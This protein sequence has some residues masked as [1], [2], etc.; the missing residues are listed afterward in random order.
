MRH[1]A[2]WAVAVNHP[3]LVSAG[4]CELMIDPG[5]YIHCLSWLN[6]GS[7]RPETH[8]AFPLQD[9]VDLFLL[10]I[11]PRNLAPVRFQCYATHGEVC[12]LDGAGSAHQILS[13]T[14]RRICS[15]GDFCEVGNNQSTAPT[16]DELLIDSC[17]H[18]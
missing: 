2:R 1:G 15:S 14:P 10:L 9:Q 18:P 12:R 11:V 5:R 17:S 13:S 4:I 16:I 6:C 8:F 3:H 7:F